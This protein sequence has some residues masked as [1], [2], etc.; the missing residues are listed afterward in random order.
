MRP[1]PTANPCKKFAS[2]TW[3]RALARHLLKEGKALAGET[4]SALAAKPTRTDEGQ[5]P[6]TGY[7]PE[8]QGAFS[9]GQLHRRATSAASLEPRRVTFPNIGADGLSAYGV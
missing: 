8:A 1:R 9:I 2:A 3:V 4:A 6:A 7:G 5:P